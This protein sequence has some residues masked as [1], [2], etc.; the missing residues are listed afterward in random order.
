MLDDGYEWLS[1]WEVHGR[2]FTPGSWPVVVRCGII[3]V[4]GDRDECVR[5]GWVSSTRNPWC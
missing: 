3:A 2:F 1:Y 4:N 5:S